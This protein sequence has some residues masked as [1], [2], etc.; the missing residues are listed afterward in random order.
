MVRYDNH[1]QQF[2]RDLEEAGLTVAERINIEEDKGSI[3][4]RLL[5]IKK[6]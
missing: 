5:I 2:E 3:V 4:M 6:S 1:S